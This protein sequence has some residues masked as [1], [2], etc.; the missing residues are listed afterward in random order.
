MSKKWELKSES[1][2]KELEGLPDLIKTL[3]TNRAVTSLTEANQIVAPNYDDNLHDPYL[4]TDMKKAV[5]RIVK[6]V[7]HQENIL[8]FGDYDADGVPASAILAE[9]FTQIGHHN[10]KVYLPDRHTEQYGLSLKNIKAFAKEGVTL[11]I[12]VD[13]GISN[14]A[15]IKLANKLGLEV[16]VTDHHTVP[17][18]LPEALAVINP[19]RL[20]DKYPYK[21]LAGAGV[22][23]KLVQAL[24][25]E[26]KFIDSI[27]V[28]WEKWLL[29]LVAIATISDMVPMTGENKVLT[30]FGLI[31]LTK[32]K[33][34]GLQA[35]YRN[36][37]LKPKF[38][39]EDDV[40]FMIA[41][42]LNSA[43]RMSHPLW[44]YKLLVTKDEV[45][46]RTIIKHL[47]GKNNLR[48]DLVTEIIATV[49]KKYQ[50]TKLPNVLVVGDKDWGL[51]VLGLAAARLVEKYDR[52][53]FVWALNGKGEI[54]GSC[55]SDGRIN[56]MDLMTEANQ[57][58]LFLNYGGHNFAGGFSLS[59]TKTN[60]LEIALQTAIKKVKKSAI[61]ESLVADQVLDLVDIAW[62]LFREMNKLAP[63]GMDFSKPVFWFKDLEI[64]T[65]RGFGKAGGH[66]EIIFK[67]TAGLEIGAI[68]FFACA[69]PDLFTSD[70]HIW[71]GVSLKPGRRVDILASIEQ[72]TFKFK[73]ELR[74]HL[75]DVRQS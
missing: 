58:K 16:I 3:L 4:L 36:L 13:C 10:F 73:P 15:E 61:E 63:F 37:K 71:T 32:T 21:H 25:T 12:T 27:P 49:D 52:P 62:P 56:V 67:Q 28:G 11:L 20:R 23:F 43:G 51:G 5:K 41:P 31:V 48:R 35:L 9:F 17:K 75:I 2:A 50:Q 1:K 55:R 39:T 45:E 70:D 68:A 30:K 64:K 40:G 24:I 19:K 33:R 38:I 42:R 29:D 54:K 22:A 34:L 74:L 69:G 59:E 6:A 8:I 53:V 47:E 46:A 44:A 7:S 57:K 60:D 14:I 18:V 66:V 72:S 65:S 26:P